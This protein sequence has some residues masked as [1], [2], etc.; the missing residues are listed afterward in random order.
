VEQDLF[1]FEFNKLNQTIT[2][3]Y[4]IGANKEEEKEKRDFFPPR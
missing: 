4:R 3:G 2:G 1:P